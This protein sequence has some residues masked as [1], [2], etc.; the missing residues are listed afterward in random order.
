MS[1]S[2]KFRSNFKDKNSQINIALVGAGQMGQGVISQ[3]SKQEGM[4]LSLII[5]RN[6]ERLEEAILRYMKN[7]NFKPKVSESIEALSEIDVDI[8]IEATGSPLAGAT[9]ADFVLKQGVDL[10]LLNVETEATIGLEL[11]RVAEE[12]GCIVTVGDGD[13]PVAAMELYNFANDL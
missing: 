3:V 1:L 8:V 2:S 11:K 9:V 5:D 6:E 10:I 7:K 12:N 13:E 4:N